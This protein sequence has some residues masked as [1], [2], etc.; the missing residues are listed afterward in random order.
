M[1]IATMACFDKGPDIV[2]LKRGPFFQ[3]LMITAQTTAR[4]TNRRETVTAT[5]YSITLL[6]LCLLSPLEAMVP[7]STS[8]GLHSV[9]VMLLQSS[10]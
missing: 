1:G 8:T 6:P 4:A 3:T 10:M 5:M 2:Y 9:V 7:Q